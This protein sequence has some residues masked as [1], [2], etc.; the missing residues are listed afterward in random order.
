MLKIQRLPSNLI[1][2]IAAGEVIERPASIVKELVENSLDSGATQISV[3]LREGGKSYVSV[4]DNGCGMDE[5]DLRLCIERHAT[6]KLPTKDLFNISTLGFRGEALPSIGAISRLTLTSLSKNS[7]QGWSLS[8]EGGQIK[9]CAPSPAYPGTKTEVRDLFFAV[10]ARLKFLK[11]DRTET[12]HVIDVMQRLSLAYPD[13]SFSLTSEQKE[14]FSYTAQEKTEEGSLARIDQVMGHKF[15]E[16]ALPVKANRDDY[17]LRGFISLPTLNRTN[18]QLQFLFVNGRPVKDKLLSGAI[19]ASY[20]DFLSYDRHPL[21]C[22]YLT[23]PPRYV[24]VNVHPAK[25]EVRF[26]DTQFVR[27]FLVSSLK[28]ALSGMQH[29]SSTG[30]AQEALNAFQTK[31]ISHQLSLKQQA[32]TSSPSVFYPSKKSFSMPHTHSHLGET[33]SEPLSMN[34]VDTFLEEEKDFPLGAACAQ[35]HENYIISQTKEGLVIVDQHAAHERLVYERLKHAVSQNQVKR[36]VLLIPEVIDLPKKEFQSLI[37]NKDAIAQFGIILESFGETSVLVRETPS[38][39]GKTDIVPLIKDMAEGLESGERTLKIEKKINEICS[40]IAC[41]GSVRSGRRL[42]LSEMN[43]LLRQ[44]EQTPYS[45]QC[46]HGR[47]TQVELKL[48]DIEKLFGRQ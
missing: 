37:E 21:L 16:N 12:Q 18:A 4:T 11:T 22:L 14:I 38:I 13:R 29:R 15:K 33:S 35:I 39:L 8:V 7:Q 46:N 47:P 5:E 9:N 42:S 26:Q 45:G 3:I 10:P 34:Q 17:A 30:I 28:Q 44:M 32:P 43:D 41:H 31:S 19:R 1:N 48:T 25:V 24:D 27:S 23:V 2:Q 36:Q 40:S 20:Q 6:S